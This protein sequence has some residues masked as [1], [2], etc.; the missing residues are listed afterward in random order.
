M[1]CGRSSQLGLGSLH[2][3]YH[4]DPR[5]DPLFLEG[6]GFEAQGK[7]EKLRIYSGADS[8]VSP[9]AATFATSTS[10]YKKLAPLALE[11]ED[12]ITLRARMIRLRR[13]SNDEKVEY[14]LYNALH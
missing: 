1:W 10:G 12:A 9:T 6:L 14:G 7:P 5:L 11:P 13:I 4:A 3:A 8:Y 2:R